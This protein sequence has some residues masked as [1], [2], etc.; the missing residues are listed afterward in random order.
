MFLTTQKDLEIMKIQIRWTKFEDA[1][2]KMP[3]A[4]PQQLK[5][6]IKRLERRRYPPYPNHQ[7]A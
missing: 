6:Q 4:N 3:D 7:L 1:N 2:N 5:L